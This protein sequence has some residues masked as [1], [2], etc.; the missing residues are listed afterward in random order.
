MAKLNCWEV[1]RCGREPNGS[2]VKELGEC[3]AAKEKRMD[4]VNS[5][6][7]GGRACWVLEGT[8]CGGKVQGN[9]A[10][11]LSNCMQCDFYQQVRKEEGADY[12]NTRDLQEKLK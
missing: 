8:L 2:K 4:G 6:K 5:G 9:F 11:K 3:A 12:K 7:N 1:T 10:E